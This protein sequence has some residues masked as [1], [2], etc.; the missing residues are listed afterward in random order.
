MGIAGTIAVLVG[1]VMIGLLHTTKVRLDP[2]SQPLSLYALTEEAWLFNTG[3]A[4]VAVGLG[5]LLASMIRTGRVSRLS[6]ESTTLLLCALGLVT[7]V[8]F[9]D[10]NA[11]GGLTTIG[12]IHWT[13]SMVAFAALPIAPV[14][15]GRRHRRSAGC[16]A[17]P[18]IARVLALVAMAL[19]AVFVAGS[20][21]RAVTPI[22]L[23]HIGGAVERALAAV[24]LAAAVL[25]GLWACGMR[26]LGKR[27]DVPDAAP[28]TAP[29][30]VEP[31]TALA[32][33]ARSGSSG[34]SPARH[35]VVRRQARRVAA[36][37]RAR[38]PVRAGS[39]RPPA[40][41]PGPW[42]PARDRAC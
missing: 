8:V 33:A 28:G 1:A 2:L 15:L 11:Q 5:L 12:R 6:V 27:A 17:L 30:I 23:W 29:S 22:S 24:E 36:P 37:E 4:T 21:I 26:P 40:R 9:P 41:W 13:A 38:A 34:T 25:V 18:G 19:V 14:L 7:L 42:Q 35:Q 32:P 39:A 10:R 31:I 3:V 20:I 16:S